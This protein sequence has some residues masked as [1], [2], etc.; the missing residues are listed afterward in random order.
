M[1]YTEKALRAHPGFNPKHDPNFISRWI[2]ELN[3]LTGLMQ[4]VG[5]RSRNPS[6]W[7]PHQGL[8]ECSRRRRRQQ[9][10]GAQ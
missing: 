5:R 2:R 7:L 8:R 4:V 3:P 6:R 1:P 10:G 9:Q